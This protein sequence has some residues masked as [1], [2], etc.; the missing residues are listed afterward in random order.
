[1]TRKELEDTIIVTGWQS[2]YIAKRNKSDMVMSEVRREITENEILSL[3]V[4]YSKNKFNQ[5]K[6]D[7]YTITNGDGKTLLTV[8]KGG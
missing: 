4:W 5:D 6:T 3:I 7:E 1:M 8:K 2:A